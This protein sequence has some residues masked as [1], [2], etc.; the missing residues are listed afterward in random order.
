ME[1]DREE[2]IGEHGVI[3]AHTEIVEIE[4]EKVEGGEKVHIQE[5]EIDE[6]GGDSMIKQK[7]VDIN[8][9]G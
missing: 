4:T 1:I 5:M 2:N 6:S 9:K 3:S 7:S 8:E